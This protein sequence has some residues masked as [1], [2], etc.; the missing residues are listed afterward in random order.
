MSQYDLEGLHDFLIHT[1]ENGV[2]KMLVDR[3]KM[4]DVHCN[5]LLKVAKGCSAGDFARHFENQDLPKLRLGP[6]ELKIKEKFWSDCTALL[7]ERGILQ[8]A[9]T[10]SQKAA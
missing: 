7:L 5:L 10:G 4:T 8:P 9:V 3:Q 6:A 2:R 1:P